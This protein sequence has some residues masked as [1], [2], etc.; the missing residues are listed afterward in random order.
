LGA[1]FAEEQAR[2]ASS[3]KART[4]RRRDETEFFIVI[5]DGLI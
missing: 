4:E 5:R 2:P 3:A 1:A